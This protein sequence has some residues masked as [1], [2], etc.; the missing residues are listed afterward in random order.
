MVLEAM[1]GA[2]H[3]GQLDAGGFGELWR[4]KMQTYDG[5]EPVSHCWL[6]HGVWL[7]HCGCV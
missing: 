2:A 7:L 5:C 4:A 1:A 3:K 6:L